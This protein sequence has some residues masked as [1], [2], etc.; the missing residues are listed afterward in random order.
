ML[1]GQ[2][3]CEVGLPREGFGWPDLVEEV[4]PLLEE[5]AQP[6]GE[7][8]LSLESSLQGQRCSDA[9]EELG[10]RGDITL[11]SQRPVWS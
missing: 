1:W 4:Q 10:C 11:P 9:P 6:E 2:S 7:K 5:V 8:A 3:P